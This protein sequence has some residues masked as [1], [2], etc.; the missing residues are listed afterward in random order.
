MRACLDWPTLMSLEF[1]CGP[2]VQLR[3]RFGSFVMEWRQQSTVSCDEAFSEAQ[4]WI[5][6]SANIN[7]L[8]TFMS[9]VNIF[10]P[11]CYFYSMKC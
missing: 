9:F 10:V 3:S 8:S 4:R 5:E 2:P 11:G 6:V 1:N 7:Y